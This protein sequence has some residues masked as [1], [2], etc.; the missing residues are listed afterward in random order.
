MSKS[1]P[2]KLK[3]AVDDALKFI[4]LLKRNNHEVPP[5]IEIILKAMREGAEIGMSAEEASQHFAQF[6]KDMDRECKLSEQTTGEDPYVCLARRDRT[7]GSLGYAGRVNAVLNPHN[8]VSVIAIHWRKKT[9]S[10]WACVWD[11]VRNGSPSGLY[12]K[13]FIKEGSLGHLP[14]SSP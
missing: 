7:E 5:Q 13:C 11:E 2:G 8:P 12:R 3:N 1:D 10:G 14:K 9:R 6:L 4:D